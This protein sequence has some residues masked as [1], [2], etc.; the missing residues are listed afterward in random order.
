ML[1]LPLEGRRRK[2]NAYA[3]LM[4]LAFTATVVS[5]VRHLVLGPVD[6]SAVVLGATAALLFGA[7]AVMTLLRWVPLVLI[8]HLV[9]WGVAALLLGN[10]GLRFYALPAGPEAALAIMASLLWMPLLFVFSTIAFDGETSLRYSAALFVLIVLVTLP[11]ALASMAGPLV[12]DGLG[13]MLQAY[14]AYAIMIVA[15]F[16]LA[17]VQQ[18]V[19]AMEETARTMRKLAN[20]DALTGLANR[21]QAEEQLARELRRAERYGRVFSLL[22]LDIDN[23]K[24]L[25]DRFGH[26]A[27]DDVLM[28]LSRRLEA[29]V[30]ASDTVAR[31]GGEEFMLLAPETQ[32]EDARRLAELVRRHVDD[33]LLADRFAVTVSLGVAS[34]RPSDTVQSLVARS[35]AAL[36]LAKRGGR[37]QVRAEIVPA[38]ATG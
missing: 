3:T 7:I 6:V 26:Q 23:F 35:D 12:T 5:L 8:E 15:L 33:N 11:H 9:L 19:A 30:R 31:W 24:D 21:R 37:N 17:D 16:F 32:L 34:Y 1:A 28:D 36:Y 14:L 13:V 38:P 22:M 25:N 29:M 27:G 10:L 18:R 20:T 4:W 2:R